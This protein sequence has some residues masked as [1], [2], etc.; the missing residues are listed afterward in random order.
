[1][2]RRLAILTSISVIALLS[3]IILSV[4]S[5]FDDSEVAANRIIEHEAI[6][7]QN[8][9]SDKKKGLDSASWKGVG[10]SPV[11]ER[12][13]LITIDILRR[14]HLSHS[15][16]P[17]KTS[18]FIDDLSKKSID[19]K[20]SFSQSPITTPSDA[21][22]FT[23]LYPTQTGLFTHYAVLDNSFLTMA[24]VL[25]QKGFTTAAFIGSEHM[26]GNNI[27]QGFD[28]VDAPKHKSN[29]KIVRPANETIEL[30]SRW[31]DGRNS[32]DKLFVWIHLYDLNEFFSPSSAYHDKNNQEIENNIGKDA[33][34][35]YLFN[36]QHL[37]RSCSDLR[38]DE[39]MR[40][41]TTSEITQRVNKYDA[42]IRYIDDAVKKIYTKIDDDGLNDNALWILTSEHGEGLCN[43][44]YDL[45]SQRIYNEQLHVPLL[46]HFPDQNISASVDKIV[47]HV[48]ILPTV[49]DLIGVSLDN[50]IKPIQG[51]SLMKLVKDDDLFPDKY[52]FSVRRDHYFENWNFSLQNEFYK[53]ILKS[54]L[55]IQEEEFYD[56]KKDPYEL[57]DISSSN[58]QKKNEFEQEVSSR[59]SELIKEPIAPKD[60]V[61]EEFLKQLESLGYLK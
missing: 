22:I 21:V 32:N 47:E 29:G 27:M 8:S 11:V 52:A 16:Y 28:H 17:L 48:D 39:N 58:S 33:F 10:D 57:S 59:V 9:G 44:S 60:I 6:I 26:L 7:N 38:S 37:K 51:E 24:E 56:L 13:F 46:L 25:K 50:Q 23:S 20:N 54:R 18:P 53:Y 1:M 61:D 31:M 30:A 2:N 40:E 36:N 4:K 19:F 41:R 14:D 42:K 12:I 15:G 5:A 35:D 49:A 45:H 3:F 43:H 34:A 55:G